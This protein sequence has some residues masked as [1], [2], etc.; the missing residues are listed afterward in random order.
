MKL[1]LQKRIAGRILKCS[2]QRIVFDNSRM[3]DIKAAITKADMRGLIND[4]A[5][6]KVPE[7][8]ISRHRARERDIKK[9]KGSGRGPGSRQGTRSARLSNKERWI[10]LIRA[11]RD[12]LLHLRD[13]KKIGPAAFRELYTKSKGGFFRSRRHIKLYIDEHKLK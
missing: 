9:K 2:R 4:G 10:G 3:E 6:M 11:Q 1:T 12:L 13:T 7:T 5:V 8:G